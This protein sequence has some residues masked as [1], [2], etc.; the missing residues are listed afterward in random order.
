M[1]CPF[2]SHEE[3]K[4]LESRVVEEAMRRR[5][6]CLGCANRFTT[7]EKA[8]FNLT[9]QKRDGRIQPFDLQ[10]ISASIEKAC[11]KQE[12]QFIQNLTKKVE[13]KVLR[14]KTNPVKSV[15]IGNAILQ[16][17]KKSDQIAYL[18]FASIY[19]GFEDPHAFKKEI[20]DLLA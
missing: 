8:Y 2:C 6:E 16:E 14:K 15:Y 4:V 5:R 17:L 13:Q 18:R 7:Y 9:V 1:Y 12:D 10:K 19:K 3:T 20:K 11:G